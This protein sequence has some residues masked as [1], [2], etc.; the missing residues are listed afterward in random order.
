MRA[1]LGPGAVSRT[2]TAPGA[3]PRWLGQII[4]GARAAPAPRATLTAPDVQVVSDSSGG[5]RRHL[6]LRVRAA[7]RTLDVV[8]SIDSGMVLDAAI[9]GR[10]ID[11]TRYRRRT[12]QWTLTYAAPTDS[13]FTLALTL[14]AGVRPTLELIARSADLPSLPDLH[15]PPRPAGVIASQEG[16]YT[17]L[18]R[19]V[20]L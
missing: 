14:K 6:T 1:A 12:P 19:R 11:T 8:M 16:D 13:G 20:R 17:A 5:G 18:H 15:V 3:P 10:A 7:P 9:D 4:G 2:D